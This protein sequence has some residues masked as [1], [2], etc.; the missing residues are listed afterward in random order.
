MENPFS[1]ALAVHKRYDGEAPP[2][3]GFA[4]GGQGSHHVRM[5]FSLYRRFHVFRDAI[6]SFDRH[7]AQYSGVSLKEKYGFCTGI[8][9]EESLEHVN[10]Q[11]PC[12]VAI[13]VALV[14]VSLLLPLHCL[15][16]TTSPSTASPPLLIPSSTALSESILLL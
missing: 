10:V 9:T 6:D 15:P 5:G 14:Q 8:M 2:V 1:K 11:M 7:Y 12:I 3:I 13:Q 4:F 16:S